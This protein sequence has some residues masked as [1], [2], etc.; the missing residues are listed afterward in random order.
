[1]C[2]SIFDIC[3]VPNGIENLISLP[4]L[5]KYGFRVTY[6]TLKSWV[7]HCPYGTPIL[8]NCDTGLHDRFTYVDVEYLNTT[9][10]ESVNMLQTVRGYFEGFTKREAEKD[11]LACKSHTILG[12]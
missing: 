9:K 7:V 5:E 4:R 1:M 3:L 10:C 11:N 8:L 12:Y 2:S 6:E